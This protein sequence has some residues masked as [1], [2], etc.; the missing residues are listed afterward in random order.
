MRP[1][2]VRTAFHLGGFGWRR[3][4]VRAWTL[5]ELSEVRFHLSNLWFRMKHPLFMAEV[6]R[7]VRLKLQGIDVL[8]A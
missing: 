5:W 8:D 6:D 4:V 1:L 2:W 3:R 7:R